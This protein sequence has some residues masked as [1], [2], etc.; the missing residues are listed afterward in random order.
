MTSARSASTASGRPAYRDANAV[1][2]VLGYLSS[3]LG[4]SVWFVALSWAAV[5]AGSASQVGLVLAAGSVP[6]AVLLLVGGALADRWGIRRT[7]IASDLVR[8]A[9]L[10]LA[11]ATALAMPPAIGPL[12]LLAAGFGIVDAV[13]LPATGA[14]PQHLGTPEQMTQ[15][16]GMRS[17]AQRVA[18]TFGAP[19]G[20]LLIA[21]G[22]LGTAFG[23]A[24]ATTALSVVA[25]VFTRV[26]PVER[27]EPQPLLRDVRSGLAYAGRHPVLL[28]LLTLATL[29]EF[30]SAGAI[31]VGLPILSAARGW[32]PGGVGLLLGALGVGATASALVLVA[33]PRVPHVGRLFA[34]LVVLMAAGVV[35]I[36]ATQSLPVTAACTGLVGMGA[37]L[38][39]SL[40]GSLVLTETTPPMVARVTALSTL[41]SLG[42]APLSYAIAGATANAYGP[43]APFIF[44][45][46]VAV[47]A[48]IPAVIAP[49]LRRAEFPH[50]D[51]DAQPL[52]S[53]EL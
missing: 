14:M 9:L 37:G 36:G 17:T 7:A 25:L 12:L 19:L 2:W 35:G 10:A 32:G 13:F 21:T 6:R 39:G 23:V 43:S 1:R 8:T 52:N 47:L 26:H 18:T 40:F 53:I 50:R 30:G 20:G 38:A 51:R 22:S 27:A 29:F 15:I 41:A 24:A 11:A 33:L 49:A 34:P 5:Q 16:Q 31:N 48:A 4:D 44:G 45:A 46:G 28:P 42:L 3:L